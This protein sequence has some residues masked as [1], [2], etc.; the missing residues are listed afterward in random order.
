[1]RRMLLCVSLPFNTFV[2]IPFIV[3]KNKTKQ[4]GGTDQTTQRTTA[5]AGG[6]FR[7]PYP[8]LLLIA[9]VLIVYLPSLSLGFT[10]LDDTIFIKEF[11]S[12]NE[13]TSNLIAAFSRGLF[14]AVKDPYYRP[15]FSDAMILNYQMSGDEPFGYHLVNVLL[16]MGVVVA[17]YRLLLRVGITATNSFYLSVIFAIHPVLT[18]AVTWIPGRNDTLLALF[19]VP[20]LSHSLAYA[21]SGRAKS[22]LLSGVFL[23]LAFFTKETAVFA[24]P[25]AFCL[26][27]LYKGVRWND[28]NML[29]QYGVWAGCF[30][31]WYAA[32]SAATIQAS[33]IGSAAGFSD[34]VH[35]LPVIIQ[36]IGKIMLPVN[37]SVFPTQEDTVLYFGLMGIVLLGA[38]V[39]LSPSRSSESLKALAAS[40][41]IFLLFLM[42]ALLVPAALN[43][44]TFEHRLY[45]PAIGILLA[46]PHTALLHNRFSEKQRAML[47]GVLCGV[48]A[49]LNVRHQYN[50]SDPLTFWT[51]AAETSPNS[52]YANMM[53]AARLD[54][55][56]NARSEQL[57]RKAY[58]L[59]PKEKYLN[60]YMAEMLQRKDSV[61]ASEAYLLEEKKI[62]D[63][64]QCDFLL[65]RVAMEKKD[66][67]A[68]ISYLERYL[69]RD[70][71]NPMAHNNLLL[72][73]VETQQPDRARGLI[74]SMQQKGMEVPAPLR[75]KLGM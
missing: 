7:I 8:V 62:S 9:A 30:F 69:Q 70:P 32:R 36:Y 42:P 53:L 40:L 73:Y 26:L 58:K 47:I 29:V 45:L 12:F 16:H 61:L 23:L 5:D 18:Q 60:F 51:S 56:E 6:G 3:S 34:M 64:V 24:A 13:D 39:V 54:K 21:E 41:G 46:L 22:L 71:Y 1:M 31:I 27:V 66:L 20:F 44:Q 35:R 55:T 11:R 72:L 37:Q 48:L 28:K 75:A 57:F 43:Q 10:E 49:L 14:D 33:G 67:N 68:S 50:F 25:A 38:L 19:V 15:L 2:R 17:L 4:S 52:A 74:K 63:Y 65:A 59:N